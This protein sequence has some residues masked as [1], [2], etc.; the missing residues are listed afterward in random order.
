MVILAILTSYRLQH[1]RLG[2]AWQYVRED[3][4]AAEAMGIDRVA[5][6]LYAYIIGAVFAGVAGC[7]F[8]AKMTAISPDSF[9]FMQSAIRMVADCMNWKE[10]GEMAVILAAKKHPATPANTAPIM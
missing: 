1:S 3:E 6:K 4:D 8:A 7:F 9:Q 10:S 2:R 5:I